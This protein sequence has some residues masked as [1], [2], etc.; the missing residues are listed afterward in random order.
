M[1]E[2]FL[3]WESTENGKS[4]LVGVY[5]TQQKAQDVVRIYLDD[6]GPVYSWERRILDI[7]PLLADVPEQWRYSK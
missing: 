5:T 2:V 4:S 3:V 1:K 6:F 7:D